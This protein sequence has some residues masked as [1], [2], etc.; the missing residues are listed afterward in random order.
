MAV[1]LAI[2][3]LIFFACREF[4]NF[5]IWRYYLTEDAKNQRVDDVI[6]DLNAYAK[7]HELSVNDTDK[8]S[9]WSGGKYIYVVLYKDT[10]L[11]YAPDWFEDFNDDEYESEGVTSDQ[12][13][14]TS[15]LENDTV[16][17]ESGN[18]IGSETEVESETAKKD[19]N[20][21]D[22]GWFSG[23]RGFERYLTEEAREKYRAAL[24]SILEGNAELSPIYCVDGTLLATVVDYSEDFMYDLIFAIS[25]IC[26]VLVVGFIMFVSLSTLTSR[27]KKLAAGV[28]LVEKGNIDAP[29]KMSG[30]D[31]ISDLA[32]DVNRMRDSVVDNMTKGQQAWE[33]N[34]GLITAMSHDIRTP[35]TVMLGYLD[36]IEFQEENE[37]NR[38]YITICKENA[39]RLKTL[40]DD[41]FSYFLVFGKND[42]ELEI[43]ECNAVDTVGTMMAEYEMLL[44][45]NGYTVEKRG[46]MPSV[47][48]KVDIV[49]LGRV[50]GN[51]FSNITKYA[52]NS[53]P[54]AVNI[55][56]DNNFLLIS[57]E[58]GVRHDS[59]TTESTGIG[60]KTSARI[61]EKMG[62]AFNI[63]QNSEA[64]TATLKVPLKK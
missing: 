38:E 52:D 27:V 25:L 29:L 41:M 26:A 55:N 8:F 31:E 33:A 3:L 56:L 62:G 15:E 48:I 50:M 9:D 21:T 64:Y 49:C 22:K 34:A 40:S 36:L 5:L 17:L 19:F 43:T 16:E 7:E 44:A 24:D 39:L 57:F 20:L 54:V 30:N 53:R 14:S 45:E 59:Y 37:T 46:D 42:I 32:D 11:I 13:E 28:R 10:N 18:E 63:T 4:G 23:D 51:I 12:S 58:N 6:S 60:V 2:A 61:M 47:D 35:L 1:A